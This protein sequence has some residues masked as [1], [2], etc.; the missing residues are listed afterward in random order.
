MKLFDWVVLLLAL[1]G[2]IFYGL[3]KARGSD[4]T[5]NYLRAGRSMPW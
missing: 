5:D 4:T 2:V 3:W 1:G